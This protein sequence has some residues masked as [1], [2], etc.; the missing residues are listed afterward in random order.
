MSP[1]PTSIDFH[2]DLMCPFAYQTRVWIRDVRE[3]TGLEVNWHFFSLEEINRQEGKKHPWEREW[4]YGWSMMRIGAWLRR[5]SMD[6]LDRW[7]ARAGPRSTS[8]AS[9]R[10]SPTWRGTSSTSSGSTPALVDLAIADPTTHDEIQ[11]EHQRV[12]AAGGYGVPTLFFGDQCLFG[13]G[14]DRPA[15]R[16]GGAASLARRHCL[17]RVPAPVRAAAPEVADCTQ[18][19]HSRRCARTWRRATG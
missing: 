14:A 15:D 2:F 11:R 9:S 6:D 7:Y 10:T 12:V 3:Q 18:G 8:R 1:R 4:S 16:R 19:D 5:T 17:V 13:P